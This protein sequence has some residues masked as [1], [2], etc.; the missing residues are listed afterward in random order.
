MVVLTYNLAAR[1]TSDSSALGNCF[2][3][4][5]FPLS[6]VS[7]WLT[8]RISETCRRGMQAKAKAAAAA[9]VEDEGDASKKGGGSS[10]TGL[11]TWFNQSLV[12]RRHA[13]QPTQ[14]ATNQGWFPQRLFC[15]SGG[16]IAV[17][18]SA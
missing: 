7:R 16:R 17:F 2:N 1:A 6:K 14:I 15:W 3:L 13:W 9:A 18:L 5:V 11:S 8:V 4:Q 10:I 12:T